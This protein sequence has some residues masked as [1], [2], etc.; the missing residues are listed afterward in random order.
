MFKSSKAMFFMLGALLIG[1]TLFI[2][3]MV[4][5]AASRGHEFWYTMAGIM[6][7][8]VLL[9]LSVMD[10]CEH[11]GD[12][13]ILFRLSSGM[14]SVMYFLFTL[15]MVVVYCHDAGER[16]ILILQI[17]GLFAALILHVLLNLAGHST[18]KQAEET[19]AR[20]A[21][22]KKFK[23]EIECLKMDLEPFFSSSKTLEKK[24]LNLSD[25]ARFAPDGL[26]GLE[27]VDQNI[28]DGISALQKTAEAKNAAEIEASVD[29]LIVLFQKRQV[30]AKGAR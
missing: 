9:S 20:Q 18:A 8:E 23:T 29:K 4:V 21:N 3:V 7:S 11:H 16:T 25:L 22:K 26:E 2:G 19:Q 6:L 5:E 24:F 30:L 10:L 28:F 1:I 14:V 12:K 13:G 27:N 17:L 15:A